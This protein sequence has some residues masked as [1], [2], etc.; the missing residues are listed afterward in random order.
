MM[1][2][3]V[4]LICSGWVPVGVTYGEYLQILRPGCYMGPEKGQGTIECTAILV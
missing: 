2:R 4:G 1:M 3:G